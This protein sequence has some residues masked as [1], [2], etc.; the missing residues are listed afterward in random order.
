MSTPAD[1]TEWRWIPVRH[2]ED[3]ADD[4]SWSDFTGT[5]Q[6]SVYRDGEDP[7]PFTEAVVRGGKTGIVITGLGP[8]TYRVRAHVTGAPGGDIP[9]VDCGTFTLE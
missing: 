7:G 9:S 4:T 3:P 5:I 6:Y 8:G 1:T 2:Q